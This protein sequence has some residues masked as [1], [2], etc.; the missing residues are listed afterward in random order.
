[1]SNDDSTVYDSNPSI[2]VATIPIINTTD[3]LFPFQRKLFTLIHYSFLYTEIMDLALRCR[4]TQ[5][6]QSEELKTLS[7]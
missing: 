7:I 1:M 5:F 4:S 2:I 3:T 6:T